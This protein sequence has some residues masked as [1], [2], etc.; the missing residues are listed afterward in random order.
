MSWCYKQVFLERFLVNEGNVRDHYYLLFLS[1]ES[2]TWYFTVC[3]PCWMET[4]DTCDRCRAV[5]L[6]PIVILCLVNITLPKVILQI[7]QQSSSESQSVDLLIYTYAEMDSKTLLVILYK[8]GLSAGL[9]FSVG[10]GETFG[11]ICGSYRSVAYVPVLEK[12]HV[13]QC[14]KNCDAAISNCVKK[15]KQICD[16]Q[17]RQ[18]NHL[19]QDFCRFEKPRKYCEVF[20]WWPHLDIIVMFIV[21]RGW[22]LGSAAPPAGAWPGRGRKLCQELLLRWLSPAVH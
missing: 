8:L 18:F 5:E 10:S 3:T 22:A 13:K 19:N 9:Y 20:W 21:R 4:W 12:Y 1:K 2:M 17:P 7:C 16:I 15:M 6:P 14:E 11:I